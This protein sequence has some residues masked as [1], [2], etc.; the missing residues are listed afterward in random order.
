MDRVD[1]RESEPTSRFPDA[2]VDPRQ[3]VGV[4]DVRPMLGDRPLQGVCR[5]PQHRSCVILEP[6]GRVVTP[7]GP[8]EHRPLDVPATDARR[9]GLEIV[10]LDAACVEL[11]GE[12]SDQLL[13]AAAGGV[14]PVRVHDEDTQSSP[15]PSRSDTP[16]YSF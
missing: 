13:R 6:T 2:G 15:P 12:L 3:V 5:K 11:V 4:D 9:K 8:V 1:D 16:R 14:V 10:D 7:V